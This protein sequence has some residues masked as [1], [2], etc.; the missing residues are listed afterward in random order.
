MR[1]LS[2]VSRKVDDFQDTG[3]IGGTGLRLK[4]PPVVARTSLS[5]K[6]RESPSALTRS[7]RLILE[8]GLS[9]ISLSWRNA[10]GSFVLSWTS[11]SAAQH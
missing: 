6:V 9:I 7:A 5:S 4:S 8:T 1:N 11:L 3:P 2:W 10:E